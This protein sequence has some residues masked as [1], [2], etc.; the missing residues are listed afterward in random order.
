MDLD[1]YLLN[2]PIAFLLPLQKNRVMRT[3]QIQNEIS[4]EQYQMA[5]RVLEAMGLKVQEEKNKTIEQK[6]DTKMTKEEY[7][8]MI[9]EARKGK[10]IRMSRE[11]MRKLM[12]E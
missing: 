9:D 12:F 1:C 10:K 8:Q 4:L 11:E 2:C 3:I 6:D 7:Y 5:V